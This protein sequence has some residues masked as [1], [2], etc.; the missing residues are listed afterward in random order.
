MLRYPDG[1]SCKEATEKVHS[2]NITIWSPTQAQPWVPLYSKC[3]P[4]RRP[5]NQGRFINLNLKII[6]ITN[7]LQYT[8]LNDNNGIA[9]FDVNYGLCLSFAEKN[10]M[11]FWHSVFITKE[12]QRIIILSAAATV[13]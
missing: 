1:E 4:V 11:Y 10:G 13:R 8:G 3:C 12:T 5:F 2:Q 7:H 6:I 9:L